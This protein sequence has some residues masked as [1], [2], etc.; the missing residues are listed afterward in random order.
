MLHAIQKE[1]HLLLK[2]NYPET[3]LSLYPQ[4]QKENQ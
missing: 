3:D 4:E 1:L 2:N